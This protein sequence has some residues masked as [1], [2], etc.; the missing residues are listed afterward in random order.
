V[1]HVGTG[2]N[3]SKGGFV[4]GTGSFSGDC[5]PSYDV[6][7]QVKITDTA[8]AQNRLYETQ[9]RVDYQDRNHDDDVHEPGET[10]DYYWNVS[11]IVSYGLPGETYTNYHFTVTDLIP[12]GM[13]IEPGTIKITQGGS[14]IDAGTAAGQ[15]VT[16]DLSALPAGQYILKVD[17]HV[18]ENSVAYGNDLYDNNATVHVFSGPEY[19]ELHT[20]HTFHN[21]LYKIHL[22]QIVL[23]H[24]GST[25]LPYVGYFALGNDGVIYNA[26]TESNKDGLHVDFREIVLSLTSTSDL[27]CDITDILPQSYVYDGFVSTT[28]ASPHASSGR[29]AAPAGVD[30]ALT[31]E[32]WVTVYIR[33][34]PN[35]GKSS[36]SFKANDFGAILLQ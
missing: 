14:D 11:N 26:L 1:I 9:V 36:W 35:P 16:W 28:T 22:R 20:N 30:F 27:V 5:Q 12:W 8:V 13:E 24:D 29:S 4:K 19:A 18:R 17:V 6:S 32:F 21:A 33:P 25:I 31:T 23:G 10:I 34:L 3:A 15:N 7:F 2:A